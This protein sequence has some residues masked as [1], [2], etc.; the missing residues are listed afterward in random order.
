MFRCLPISPKEQ[1]LFSL[2][3]RDG[4]D[5]SIISPFVSRLRIQVTPAVSSDSMARLAELRQLT[6]LALVCNRGFSGSLD[7]IKTTLQPTI[8]CGRLRVFVLQVVGGA[9]EVHLEDLRRWNQIQRETT[10][11]KNVFDGERPDLVVSAS[12]VPRSFLSEWEE[13]DA[14]LQRAEDSIGCVVA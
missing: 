6:H 13:S 3:S 5:T 14:F 8:E 1:Y 12:E 11:S 9:G 4:L 7:A 2:A 10:T